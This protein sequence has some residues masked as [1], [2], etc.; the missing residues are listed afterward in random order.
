[1]KSAVLI[2][3]RP[4]FILY[5]QTHFRIENIA[6]MLVKEEEKGNKYDVFLFFLCAFDKLS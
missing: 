5:K 2:K 4:I 6:V 3:K 1:M